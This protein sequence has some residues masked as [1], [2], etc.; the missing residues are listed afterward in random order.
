MAGQ[1]FIIDS[2]AHLGKGLKDRSLFKT[3]TGEQ[4]VAL[5]DESGI[6]QACVFAPLWEGP[7][8]DGQEWIDPNYE[9]GNMEVYEAVQQYPDRLYG[10]VRVN[11]NFGARAERELR[12]WIEDYKFHGIKM[13][14]DWESWSATNTQL[15]RM[16][17][18]FA[19]AYNLP[20]Y[21]HTG[22]YPKCQP[23]LFLPIAEEYPTVNLI[24]GHIGYEYHRD[25]IQV[26][27]RCP[28]VFVEPAG[29]SDAWVINQ[30]VRQASAR[31]VVWGSDAPFFDPKWVSNKVI[32]QPTISDDDKQLILAGNM[33]RMLGVELPAPAG[34]AA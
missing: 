30:A 28:N 29:N 25:A 24:L 8:Y 1:F 6:D 22:Y 20:C 15:Y 5:L 19:K 3:H 13:H 26:A 27:A 10:F 34:V 31:Q 12:K 9:H 23:L 11:P 7:D 21:I 4:F 16:Q 33:A 32:M 17:F 14:P 18:E 2:H